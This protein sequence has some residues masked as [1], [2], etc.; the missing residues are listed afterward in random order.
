M[1][2][3]DRIME[4]NSVLITLGFGGIIAVGKG[5]YNQV[6]KSKDKTEERFKNL[7]FANVALLH[8]KI[9]QQ[10]SNFIDSGFISLDDLENLEYLWRG[11][12]NLGGNGTGEILYNKVKDLP[13]KKMEG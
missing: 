6:K 11:Y 4:L 5:I 12:K 3:L 10:C 8:D 2:F 13:N 9:Y 7:E 1:Y